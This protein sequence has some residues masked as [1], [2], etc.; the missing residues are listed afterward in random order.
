MSRAGW[1]WLEDRAYRDLFK[2][3]RKRA[4]CIIYIDEID[5][6]GK[7][8]SGGVGPMDSSTGEGEQTL[9]QLLVEMDGMASKEGV[10]MLASTN[11]AD[12]LDKGIRLDHEPKVYS[13]RL[14][15][16]TPGFSG[17]DIANVVNE[18]ALHAARDLK[19]TVTRADLEYAVERV[20][21]GTEK[22]STVMPLEEK[23]V[24]AMH[25]SGRALMSWLTPSASV[26]LKVTIVPRTNLSLGFSQYSHQ[27]QKLYSKEELFAK[28]CMAL[29]GRVAEIITFNRSSTGA[30]K[31]LKKVTDLA[32]AMVRRFGMSEKIGLLSY[33]PPGGESEGK[34]PYSKQLAGRIDL[35][36][37]TL[38]SRAFRFTEEILLKNRDK[39]NTLSMKKLPQKG[40]ETKVD[41]GRVERGLP[42][43]GCGVKQE[44]IAATRQGFMDQALLKGA[45]HCAAI[46]EERS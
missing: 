39:L 14:A 35:E 1:T 30:E 11:R 41:L 19:A 46:G 9:N 13:R 27:E 2:E 31:D 36:A 43:I 32:Y 7:K 10:L 28:M 37:R 34:R 23:K 21:G 12:V 16:L 45:S 26:L 40:K 3:G 18:A 8:R 17:A 22:R 42:Q 4:P 6:M 38:V 20:V 44:E 25:E 5:A 29:G 24:V 15:Q 33:V